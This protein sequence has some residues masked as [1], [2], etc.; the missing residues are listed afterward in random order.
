VT[1]KEVEEE[2]GVEDEGEEGVEEAE[3][4]VEDVE[5]EGESF[6]NA[7]HVSPSSS[8]PQCLPSGEEA[9]TKKAVS[10]TAIEATTLVNSDMD[11]VEVT[12]PISPLLYSPNPPSLSSNSTL[13]GVPPSLTPLS[14]QD[15]PE[16]T[17]V[18]NSDMDK[19]NLEEGLE[20]HTKKA[21]PA[22]A[23]VDIPLFLLP[24]VTTVVNSDVDIVEE[25]TERIRD[26]DDLKEGDIQDDPLIPQSHPKPPLS[27]I[28]VLPRSYPVSEL[29]TS[30]STKIVDGAVIIATEEAATTVTSSP[31]S[32]PDTCPSLLPPVS[33]LSI[34]LSATQ[35]QDI[36]GAVII[37]DV[38][39]TIDKEDQVIATNDSIILPEP[40]VMEDKLENMMEK[41]N[42][43]MN[44]VTSSSLESAST[45]IVL[46]TPSSSTLLITPSDICP[47]FLP[48]VRYVCIF[49]DK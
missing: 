24:E 19:D 43:D 11:I 22:S 47:S 45:S 40:T 34:S 16:V 42:D 2:E 6:S 9:H 41:M 32:A 39:T 36:D 49:I 37:A 48:P 38:N 20:A 5:D 4:G 44:I 28:P 31:G 30:L 29:P 15:K 23:I 13:E 18:A 14:I 35:T 7:P 10:V 1:D 3:R 25:N 33:E 12:L 27:S 46:P 17:T 26:K 8:I 21:V